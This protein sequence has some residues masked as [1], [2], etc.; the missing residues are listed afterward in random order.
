LRL[1]APTPDPSLLT[2]KSH[3]L[4][5]LNTSFV[6]SYANLAFIPEPGIAD[7]NM[8]NDMR[9]PSEVLPQTRGTLSTAPIEADSLLL[10]T[11]LANSVGTPQGE[12]VARIRIHTTE[13]VI[14]R[15]VRAGV[16]TAEWAHD[17]PD[18]RAIIKHDLAPIFDSNQVEG[19]VSFPAHRYQTL[20][21]L[22]KPARVTEV[23]IANVTQAAPLGI[24]S[25]SLVN[26]KTA[27]TET[28][29]YRPADNWQPVYE[30]QETLIMRNAR[31]LPRAWLV[32]EAEAVDGEEALRRIRGESATEFDP[33]RSVLLEVPPAEFPRLPGGPI[34]ANS[35][36]R[37][38]R[39]EPN[40]LLIET[41]ASTASVLVLSEI[42]Y[43][44]WVASID[45]Q[46]ARIDVADYLLRGITLP[47]GQHS[48]EMHFAA[49]A[50]RNGAIISALTL[51]L[52][53]GLSVYAWRRGAVS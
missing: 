14:E 35:S 30:Q 8:F 50:A 38:T 45:G 47:A 42:F 21:Q 49:P 27:V 23:E 18:V 25:A 28:L 39:Y 32:A 29:G 24:Y 9:V 3:V 4:D 6:L 53:V 44:G 43:P 10:V 19:P 22:G 5:I 16:D 33:R 40:R 17:R 2:A 34:A 51:C 31:V 37:I 46:P 12:T 11:S 15:E 1:N 13:G 26:S 36:A 20:I 52:V 7:G 41:N 48:V